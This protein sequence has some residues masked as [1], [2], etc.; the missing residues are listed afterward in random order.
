MSKKIILMPVSA[1]V[2]VI[3][4]LLFPGTLGIGSFAGIV[5]YIIS[6]VIWNTYEKGK[7]E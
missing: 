2:M 5:F 1:I 7:H 3:F 6:L 4:M